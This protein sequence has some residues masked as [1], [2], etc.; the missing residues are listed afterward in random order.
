[1]TRWDWLREL[2]DYMEPVLLKWAAV[3][4]D[5]EGE[6]K[7]AQEILRGWRRGRYEKTVGVRW[8]GECLTGVAA[9]TLA[10]LVA[11]ECSE[12]IYERTEAQEAAL[13]LRNA[14]APRLGVHG[15]L[16]RVRERWQDGTWHSN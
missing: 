9:L 8:P 15:V 1:M 10:A 3:S 7:A 12:D 6:H 2:A 13:Y 4:S 16:A 5:P 14:I 11:A